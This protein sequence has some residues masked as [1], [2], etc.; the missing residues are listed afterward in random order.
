MNLS[1]NVDGDH[2][3]TK[4]ADSTATE[5]AIG[6]ETRDFATATLFPH[7]RRAVG[8]SGGNDSISVRTDGDS[9]H[10]AAMTFET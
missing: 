10:S 8:E 6:G 1:R 3:L 4:P 2:R 7:F 9:R 5:V